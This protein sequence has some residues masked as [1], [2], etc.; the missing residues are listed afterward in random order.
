MRM[1]TPR[2]VL[3]RVLPALLTVL[4]ASPAF[5]Q[6]RAHDFTTYRPSAPATRIADSE[7]PSIDGDISDPV[8]QKA[9]LINEFY[10]LEPSEGQPSTER[11]EVRVLYDENNIYFS[12]MNYDDDP[13]GILGRIKARDGSIEVDDVFRVYL[14]PNMTRR[15]GYTFEVNPA[16]SRRDGLIQ[17][18]ADFLYEW[19]T[20]WSAKTR[21]L[22]NGWSIEMAIPFRSIS[23]TA[24]RND[25]GFDLF[26]LIRR[27]NERTRWSSVNIGIQSQDISHSGT[28]AGLKDINQGLEIGRAHV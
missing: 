24:G 8:W 17:N 4:V 6:T 9:P 19:N 26:R 5:A 22:P 13:K 25:W 11:T 18:N 1:P 23:Y 7:A 27:K 10:Q 14:D 21:I 28:L 16:G 15:N 12:V 20:I 3:L 2:D